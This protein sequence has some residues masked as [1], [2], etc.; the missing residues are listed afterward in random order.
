M[1][2]WEGL[3][4]GET[5]ANGEREQASKQHDGTG[6]QSRERTRGLEGKKRSAS[7][8]LSIYLLLN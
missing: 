4:G 2:F 3:E 7:L 6:E 8:Y 5:M 1:G